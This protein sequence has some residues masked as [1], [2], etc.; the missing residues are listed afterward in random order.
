VSDE[1]LVSDMVMVSGSDE[2]SVHDSVWTL[3]FVSDWVLVSGSVLGVG[4]GLVYW[5]A[6]L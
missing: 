1:V 3:A 4:K 6:H 2:A 5:K